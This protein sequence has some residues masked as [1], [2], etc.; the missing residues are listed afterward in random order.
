M[1]CIY[2]DQEFAENAFS[3]EHI[4]PAGLGG[5]LCDSDLFR[6]RRASRQSNNNL[7]MF[8]DKKFMGNFFT[9][10][11]YHEAHR[12]FFDLDSP[13]P[14]P[15]LFMG[16]S[17][18]ES[19][20]PNKVCEMWLGLAGEQV[21]R[22]RN[23]DGYDWETVNTGN[24]RNR[25]KDPGILF[26]IN[27]TSEQRWIR[28]TFYSIKAT[29]KHLPKLYS[30]NVHGGKIG[31]SPAP[32]FF[33]DLN[34]ESKETYA[35]LINHITNENKSIG[36][37]IAIHIND[38][39][40]FIPKLAIGFGHNLF[41]DAFL[42]TTY[43]QELKKGLWFNHDR[44]DPEP[45]IK[46]MCNE[47]PT[48]KETEHSFL[49]IEGTYTFIF[50]PTEAGYSFNLITPGKRMY[51]IALTEGIELYPA[52]KDTRFLSPQVFVLAPG[53]DFFYGP[54]EMAEYLA[55]LGGYHQIEAL[56]NLESLR[57]DFQKILNERK[58]HDA[59]FQ[60]KSGSP[61]SRG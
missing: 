19:I 8:V 57:T 42:N 29:F 47:Y 6:T 35:Q 59:H 36:N 2:K 52:I 55:Y 21:Y 31:S 13:R 20:F 50:C 54:I 61:L 44:D 43:Y 34:N 37:R 4:F 14:A 25:K 41:G 30:V 51:S 1:R 10:I 15:L 16:H 11:D 26:H 5:K 45:E 38:H 12:A 7:G 9:Q 18:V 32:G 22:L 3:L 33:E 60:A 49:N 27:T 39:Y 23:H 24:P 58:K 46:G 56:N 48:S 28:Q 53:A 40:R 17:D